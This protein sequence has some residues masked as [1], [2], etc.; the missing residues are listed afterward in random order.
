MGREAELAQLHG[1]LDKALSGERQ[2]VFVTGEPGIGKTTVVEAFLDQ[3]AADG[4]IWLGR[5][6]CQRTMKPR[7]QARE[8]SASDGRT[9]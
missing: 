8:D 6:Q 3:L 9:P 5:G 7:A 4:Q 1:W 2:I